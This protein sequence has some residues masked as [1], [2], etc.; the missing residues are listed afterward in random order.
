MFTV[1]AMI[2]WL[3]SWIVPNPLD[4][5]AQWLYYGNLLLACIFIPLEWPI[6]IAT[7]LLVGFVLVI[8]F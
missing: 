6:L 7:M 3:L 5:I 1:S 4:Q 8:F 2:S